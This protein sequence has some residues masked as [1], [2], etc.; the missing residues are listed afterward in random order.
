MCGYEY[1]TVCVK[2]R[3]HLAGFQSL[4]SLCRFWESNSGMAARALINWGILPVQKGSFAFFIVKLQLCLRAFL[5]LLLPTVLIVSRPCSLGLCVTILVWASGSET[6]S[7]FLSCWS[8]CLTFFQLWIRFW[9][10]FLARVHCASVLE[11]SSWVSLPAN[12]LPYHRSAFLSV[13]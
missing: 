2:V 13:H 9:P 7:P 10:S 8:L 3:G 1:A 11:L 6:L 4:L 5:L 12:Q